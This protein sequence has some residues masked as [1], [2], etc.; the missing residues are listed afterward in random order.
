MT[1]REM[2]V[3]Y[4]VNCARL[5]GRM[6][7]LK[8]ALKTEEDPLEAQAPRQRLADLTALYREGRELALHMERYYDRRYCRHAKFTF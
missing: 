3:E 7:W 4:R 2:A 8:A 1:L 5:K 6:D